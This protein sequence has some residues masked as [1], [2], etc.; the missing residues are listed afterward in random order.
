MIESSVDVRVVNEGAQATW[1]G[2]FGKGVPAPAVGQITRD[3]RD[4]RDTG[5][6]RIVT[7]PLVYEPAPRPAAEAIAGTQNCD[8]RS[9]AAQKSDAAPRGSASRREM[10]AD[11]THG[12]VTA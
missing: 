5:R 1:G 4:P 10:I 7:L 6:S 9:I 2:S 8:N 11:R 3:T 12:R